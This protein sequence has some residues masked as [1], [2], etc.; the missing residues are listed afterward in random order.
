MLH[1]MSHFQLSSWC[2]DILINP[3]SLFFSLVAIW[4]PTANVW[5]PLKN[6]SPQAGGFSSNLVAMATKMVLTWRVTDE[7]LSL[8]F[9][10]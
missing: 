2:L 3:P 1:C 4:P 8:V 9:D 5:S 10:I 7:T 6:F